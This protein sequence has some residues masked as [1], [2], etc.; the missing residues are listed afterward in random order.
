MEFWRGGA[1]LLAIGWWSFFLFMSKPILEAGWSF[2]LWSMFYLEGWAS[3]SSYFIG[4]AIFK[5]KLSNQFN[6]RASI[7]RLLSQTY[8]EHGAYWHKITLTFY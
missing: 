1:I 4:V 2:I 8:A 6:L 7:F 3:R 5:M